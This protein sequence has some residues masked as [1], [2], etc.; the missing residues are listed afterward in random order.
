MIETQTIM[1]VEHFFLLTPIILPINNPGQ[2]IVVSIE[3]AV[4]D[5]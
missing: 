5:V 4:C 3:V 1:I 2:K